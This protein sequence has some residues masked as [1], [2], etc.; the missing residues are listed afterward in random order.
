MGSVQKIGLLLL[1]ACVFTASA[2]AASF[3]ASM[4]S[5]ED[6]IFADEIV[7]FSVQVTNNLDRASIFQIYSIDPHWIIYAEQVE[8]ASGQTRSID[9]TLDPTNDV[10]AGKY[11]VPITVRS[12]AA[13][14]SIQIDHDV[15]I[16]SDRF[17]QYQ[18]SI[19][20]GIEVGK[21]SKVDPTQPVEVQ[22]RVVNKN[23]LDYETLILTLESPLFSDTYQTVLNPNGD[24]V[25]VLTYNV[26][27][28]T[29]PQN[30][31][32]SV[33][34]STPSAAIGQPEVVEFEVVPVYPA[35]KRDTIQ[36]SG[37]LKQYWEITFTNVGNVP[38]SEQVYIPMGTVATWFTSASHEFEHVS[39]KDG[40][41]AMF[42]VAL[43]PGQTTTLIVSTNYRIFVGT[44]VILIILGAAC[45]ALYYVFRSPI[46]I[47]RKVRTLQKKDDGISKIKVLLNIR[48]RTNKA[49]EDIKL[50][51][52][53]SHITDIEED[54][55]VGT[56]KPSKVLKSSKKGTL[57]R[58]DFTSLEPY[59]E[60]IV[61]YKLQSK[62]SILGGLTLPATVVSFLQRG[63]NRKV[64][65]NSFEK[66]E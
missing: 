38:K 45:L 54:F 34:M 63:K 14:E 8:I 13:R 11:T 6:R 56:V 5:S 19:F 48:N 36:E 51:E 7:E 61:T 9:V 55:E 35:F 31:T 16:K 20:L 52:R 49:I 10:T 46:V 4:Q 47:V 15:T 29:P 41:A 65:F 3:T 42:R 24:F 18:P 25:K 26:D 17:R 64:S 28:Q 12:I 58:W 1:L 60:R 50:Y 2:Y 37:A 32:L 66:E 59:E 23:P 30:M 43:D 39:Y 27:A 44:V 57:V 40:Q 21:E 53:L 62:L 33:A 22:L